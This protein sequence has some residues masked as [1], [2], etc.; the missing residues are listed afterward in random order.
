MGRTNDAIIY[1]GQVQL[2]V[3][4]SSAR[5][6]DLAENL[7]SI[8]SK[9]HGRPFGEIFRAYD[10]DFYKVDPMLFSPALAIVTAL[11]TGETFRAGAID[12]ELISASF[13]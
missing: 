11:E 13:G 2:F 3:S 7:P 9:D 1:G 12:H 4:G 5:A 6:R 10:G 8:K